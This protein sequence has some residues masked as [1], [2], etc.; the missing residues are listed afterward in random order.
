MLVI[1]YH[2]GNCIPSRR[3]STG[4][5]LWRRFLLARLIKRFQRDFLLCCASFIFQFKNVNCCSSIIAFC[6]VTRLVFHLQN[7]IDDQYVA[8]SVKFIRRSTSLKRQ[9]QPLIDA[10]GPC[11]QI[12]TETTVTR[13]GHLDFILMGQKR[14]IKERPRQNKVFD[15]FTDIKIRPQF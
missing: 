5:T 9:K 10:Q 6:F 4:D 15:F 14:T 13:I 12:T 7:G 3:K 1:A 8:I 11:F 2:F